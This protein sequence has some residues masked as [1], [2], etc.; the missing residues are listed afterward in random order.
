MEKELEFARSVTVGSLATRIETI[1]EIAN[2]LNVVANSDLPANYYD[3]YIVG[4][5]RV[6]TADLARVAKRYIDP[7]TRRSSSSAIAR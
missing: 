2:R 7:R 1:D 3:D 6:T 5:G 4:I